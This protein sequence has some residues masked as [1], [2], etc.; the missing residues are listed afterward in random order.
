[1]LGRRVARS[2]PEDRRRRR[3]DAGTNVRLLHHMSA[4]ADHP[5]SLGFPEGE[6]LKGLLCQ[7]V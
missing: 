3:A 6:Y 5:V 2:L 7:L 1:V 4:A